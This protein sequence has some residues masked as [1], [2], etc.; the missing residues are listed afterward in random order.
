MRSVSNI[1]FGYS[2]VKRDM[3]ERDAWSVNGR[4]NVHVKLVANYR[5][6]EGSGEVPVTDIVCRFR[7]K[8]ARKT[9]FLHVLHL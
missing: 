7:K 3:P 1:A 4:F 5:S 8:E 2:T 6:F 9:A